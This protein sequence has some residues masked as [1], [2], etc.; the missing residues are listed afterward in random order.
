MNLVQKVRKFVTT[1]V[2]VAAVTLAGCTYYTHIPDA[3]I[4]NA[5]KKPTSSGWAKK[6]EG[7]EPDQMYE[8]AFQEPF[9]EMTPD[10]MVK[11]V[12]TPFEALIYCMW[13]ETRNDLDNA[14]PDNWLNKSFPVTHQSAINC[15]TIND[16][17]EKAV[18]AATLLNDDGYPPLMLTMGPTRYF[19]EGH[20]V[21]LYREKN[22]FKIVDPNMM[23]NRKSKKGY[24]S[25]NELIKTL[26]PHMHDYSVYDLSKLASDWK[27]TTEN[28]RNRF[29]CT[30]E[31]VR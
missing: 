12:K 26:Y 5:P 28:L 16:C 21:L 6:Y 17:S 7:L 11:H 9:E 23:W 18:A 1:A 20:L 10:E 27:T 29:R 2:A 13:L 19:G 24:K 25:V 22:L 14:K 31:V 30:T 8:L 15:N 3:Q 4:G